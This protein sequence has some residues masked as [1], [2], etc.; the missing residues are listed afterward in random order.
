MTAK[1]L[2]DLIN[3]SNQL[4]GEVKATADIKKAV[5][6]FFKEYVKQ[7]ADFIDL[8]NAIGSESYLK[9]VEFTKDK[10][11]EYYSL[12]TIITGRNPVDAVV[13]FENCVVVFDRATYDKMTKK[14]KKDTISKVIG[15]Y[16]KVIDFSIS[17]GLSLE[18]TQNILKEYYQPKK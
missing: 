13:I 14:Y 11:P 3:L 18:S 4:D 17:N 9:L 2:E 15:L 5:N 12:Q 10:Y 1:E 6:E 8:K 16:G 7:N